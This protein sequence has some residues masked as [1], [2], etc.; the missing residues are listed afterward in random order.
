[1]KKRQNTLA[2]KLTVLWI[3]KNRSRQF[4]PKSPGQLDFQKHAKSF[5][6][7]ETLQTLYKRIV[8]PHFRY[9]CSVWGCTGS[10]EINQLKKLQKRAARTITNSS[11]DAPSRPLIRR[12]GMEDR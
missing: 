5:L 8:E 4:L 7:K 9:R 11:F 10:T 1:M 2:C 6:P 12:T 3:G